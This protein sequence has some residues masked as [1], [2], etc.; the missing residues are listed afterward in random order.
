MAHRRA[1][2]EGHATSNSPDNCF[3]FRSKLTA[4]GELCYF[5]RAALRSLTCLHTT[6]P[7]PC[8][9]VTCRATSDRMQ[10]ARWSTVRHSICSEASFPR[11]RNGWQCDWVAIM[12][13]NGGYLGRYVSW[14]ATNFYKPFPLPARSSHMSWR[15]IGICPSG[16]RVYCTYLS[17][18]SE[19]R[20]H[21]VG[22]L[23]RDKPL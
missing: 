22:G 10:N 2:I 5:P 23:C 18:G 9:V 4:V 16:K 7:A 6:F 8:F 20:A 15:P 12:S 19:S 13:R 1:P 3:A 17:P 21:L 11:N 14:N